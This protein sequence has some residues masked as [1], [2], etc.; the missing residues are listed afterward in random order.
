MLGMKTADPRQAHDLIFRKGGNHDICIWLG[1]N[2]SY[3]LFRA[4]KRGGVPLNEAHL[5]LSEALKSGRPKD[6][7]AQQGVVSTTQWLSRTRN[8]LSRK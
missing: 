1:H 8:G 5:S 3:A 4:R 7:I 6:F 2:L